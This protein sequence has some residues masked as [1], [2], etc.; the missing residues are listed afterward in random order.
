MTLP[1]APRPAR[2]THRRTLPCFATAALLSISFAAGAAAQPA[3]LS[4]A[5][6]AYAAVDASA[7]F[8]LQQLSIA[9]WIHPTGAGEN[10]GG[11]I[12]TAGQ[13]PGQGVY[14]CSYWTGWASDGR[15][16]AM[17]VNQYSVRGTVVVSQASVPIG[18]TAHVALTFDGVTLRLYVNGVLDQA[19]PYG[20][21]GV[22]YVGATAINL[23]A[24]QQG[25]G[26]TFNRFTGQL[27]EVALWGRA[28]D[29]GEVASLAGCS[30]PARVG[31]LLAYYPFTNASLADASGRAHDAQAQGDVAFNAPLH[32]VCPVDLDDGS[33][34]GTCDAGVDINDLLFFLAGYEAGDAAIDL[35][36]G[37]GDGIPDGGV[38]INDLLFFLTHYE[39][40]C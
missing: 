10:G 33:G 9:A 36:N 1:I 29:A 21:T 22:D 8:T 39:A 20:F 16:Q 13:Q 3:S 4:L 2:A 23:G 5:S 11:T 6:R 37:S 25:P 28:L 26:Y 27:D 24:F 18:Q 40:G 30:S 17:V 35:D 14:L 12:L 32:A 31:G 34:A 7:D 19:V 38:D 15:V